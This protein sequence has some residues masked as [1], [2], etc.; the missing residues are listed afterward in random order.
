MDNISR[1]PP[2]NLEDFSKKSLEYYEQVKKK[3]ENE[4]MSK[5]VALDYETRQ[6]WLGETASESLTKAKEQFPNKLF[7]LLQVGSPSTFSVQSFA[8]A[9]LVKKGKDYGFTW[10]H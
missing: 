6:Y 4:A 10:A 3:L 9:D 2:V 5:F 8:S 7:Y 1:Q